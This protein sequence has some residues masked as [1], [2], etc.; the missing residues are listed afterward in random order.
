MPCLEFKV[1]LNM[2]CVFYEFVSYYVLVFPY[3]QMLSCEDSLGPNLI[4]IFKSLFSVE[5]GGVY[6]M[7]SRYELFFFF[8]VWYL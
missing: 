5:G 3:G 1:F 8:I 4:Y 7:I 6:F 2:S